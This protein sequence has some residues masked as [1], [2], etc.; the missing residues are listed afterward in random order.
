MTDAARPPMSEERTREERLR[1]TNRKTALTLLA[2]VVL[3]FFG[4]IVSRIVAGP[5]MS[6]AVMGG[7][8]FLFLIVAILRLLRK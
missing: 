6:V 5:R 8:V 7:A 1:A 3:F 2:I 4:I